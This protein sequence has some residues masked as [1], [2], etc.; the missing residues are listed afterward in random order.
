MNPRCLYRHENNTDVAFQPIKSFY[1]SEKEV[2]KMRVMWWDIGEC[3]EPRCMNI[4]QR[5]EIK[6]AD[7]PKWKLY[8]RL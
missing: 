1:V 6:K 7:L 5:I 8:R 2:L 4:E 3:H